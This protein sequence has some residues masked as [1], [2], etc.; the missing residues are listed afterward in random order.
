MAFIKTNFNFLLTLLILFI[1]GSTVCFVGGYF[2]GVKYYNN[3]Y[4]FFRGHFVALTF[5]LFSLFVAYKTKII[6]LL[7]RYHTF[8]LITNFILLILVFLPGIGKEVNGANRWINLV[9]FNFQP[10]EASKVIL[11]IL[12]PYLL[13]YHD[14][15]FSFKKVVYTSSLF[16][17]SCFLIAIEP[18][19]SNSLLIFFLGI[20]LLYISK[21]PMRYLVFFLV[22]AF[23]LFI[24]FI[25]DKSHIFSRLI[26]FNPEI[27][28]YGKGYHLLKSL[29]SIHQGGLFGSPFT[30]YFDA[31]FPDVHTDFAFALFMKIFG[32][33]GLFILFFLY[34]LLVHFCLKISKKIHDPVIKNISLGITF[35]LILEITV[36]MF[37]NIGLFPTTGLTLFLL[38]SGKN[39]MIINFF[40]IGLML[41]FN[42]N[43]THGEL[44]KINSQ[45]LEKFLTQ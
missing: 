20:F 5:S 40:L 11:V 12:L 16:G 41:N 27:D 13:F 39:S 15:K 10:S 36:H 18:N 6:Y 7:F 29:K 25:G 32:I 26:F 4:F 44:L 17:I 34:G 8:F 23:V 1:I 21:V 42:K 37:V 22:L 31:H 3:P 24:F 30:S 14:A 43:F 35:L 45:G 33:S 2:I 28:P 9:V 38:S 19:L